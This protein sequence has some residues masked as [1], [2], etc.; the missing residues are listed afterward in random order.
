VQLL[1]S[2]AAAVAQV[3]STM[4]LLLPAAGP[5][6]PACRMRLRQLSVLGSVVGQPPSSFRLEDA[7]QAPGQ[8][9]LEA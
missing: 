7:K 4:L 6:L 9:M 8:E 5:C 3:Q 1:A 2:G